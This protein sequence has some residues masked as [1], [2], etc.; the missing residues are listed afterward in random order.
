MENYKYEV[1]FSFCKE[2]ES[3]A[4][5]LNDLLNDR[6]STF[7]YYEKQKELA[8]KDGE[9]E[10]KKVFRSESR[11]VVVLYKEKWGKTPWTR[12]EEDAIRERAYDNGYNFTLFIPIDNNLKMPEWLP[13]QRLW[14]GFE[15]YGLNG[16]ASVIES[17]IQENDG[18]IKEESA[19]E[20][21]KRLQRKILFESQKRQFLFSPNGFETALKEKT[22]LFL[23]IEDIANKSTNKEI[24]LLFIVH[25]SDNWC[26][27]FN[28]DFS[29]QIKWNQVY[30]NSLSE[31]SLKV[32]LTKPTRNPDNPI[33]Y[34]KHEFIFDINEANTYGWLSKDKIFHSTESLANFLFKMLLDKI[35]KE[36]K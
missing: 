19:E 32:E 31:S 16:A 20:K 15:R 12:M 4:S 11:V 23:T 6:Y 36:L 7:I 13:R 21:A 10:F 2:D 34:S 22:S 3:F 1:A 24:G 9:V 33:I 27:C 17:K 26:N 28:N 18:I 25:K 8:G 14:Y 30:R 5:H 29:I 35:E